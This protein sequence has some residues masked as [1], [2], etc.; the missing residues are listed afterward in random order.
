M[1]GGMMDVLDRKILI[2]TIVW[3]ALLAFYFCYLNLMFIR[4]SDVLEILLDLELFVLGVL[5]GHVLLELYYSRKAIRL[6]K[7]E[8]GVNHD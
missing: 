4:G 2:W 6:L 7:E 3:L 8:D 1:G 5:V